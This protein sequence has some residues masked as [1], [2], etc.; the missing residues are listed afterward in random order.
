MSRRTLLSAEQRTRLFAIPTDRAEMAK[1]YVLGAED[2]T[3]VRSKRRAVNR[4]GFAVQLCLLR[5]PGQGLGP[6]EHP[7]EA[8]LAFVAEQLGVPAA[9]FAEYARPDQTRREHATELQVWAVFFHRQGE[10]RDC[11]FEN[12]GFRAS[13]LNLVTAAIVHWNTTYLDHSVRH[14]R[15][16]GGG[17]ARRTARPRRPARVGAHRAHQRLTGRP[18]P[19]LPATS[20]RC[21]TF[22]LRSYSK[23]LSVQF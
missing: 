21:A 10:F 7:P 9:A 6:G 1:H 20:V 18:P 16:R 5:Y 17:R 3:L 14:L 4:L 13:G 2:L 22:L 12:Q 11:T 8:M 15:A 23:P 19:G